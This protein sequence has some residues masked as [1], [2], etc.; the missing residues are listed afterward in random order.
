MTQSQKKA[1]D[2]RYNQALDLWRY[3]G[4]IMDG[5]DIVDGELI[6]LSEL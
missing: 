6:D 2:Y 3:N 1:S 4:I 5:F